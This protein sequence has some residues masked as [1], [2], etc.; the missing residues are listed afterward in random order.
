MSVFLPYD[1]SS[2]S[3][4]HSKLLSQFPVCKQYYIYSTILLYSH[5]DG[6]VL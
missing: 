4:D 2:E 1:Q 5:S 3:E 6:K